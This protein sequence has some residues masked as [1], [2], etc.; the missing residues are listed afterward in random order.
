MYSQSELIEEIKAVIDALEDHQPAVASWIVQG[1]VSAHGDIQG[2]DKDFYVLCAFGHVR[3]AVREVFRRYRVA[4]DEEPDPQL[5]MPGFERL[6][7][8]Y[9]VERDGDQIAVPIEQLTD[10]E[11]D[12]KIAELER[13]AAGCKCHAEELRRYKGSRRA[14]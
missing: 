10:Q 2:T 14:A 5:I 8:R 3:T 7:K 9:L 4:P 12:E 1:I 11:I 6:Q 13:M